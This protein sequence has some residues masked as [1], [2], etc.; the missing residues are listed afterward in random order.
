MDTELSLKY[1]ETEGLTP[2]PDSAAAIY[3]QVEQLVKALPKKYQESTATTC[4]PLGR[5]DAT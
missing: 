2:R 4:P 5:R 3:A 1:A